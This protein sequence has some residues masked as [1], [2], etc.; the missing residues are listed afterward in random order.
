MYLPEKWGIKQRRVFLKETCV[1]APSK[2]KEKSREA[3]KGGTSRKTS[4]K[5]KTAPGVIP[6]AH[7]EEGESMFTPESEAHKTPGRARLPKDVPKAPIDGISFH[8]EE[9]T[10]K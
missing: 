5:N 8:F 4:C 6:S 3:G 2:R 7:E 10:Q 1:T 9:A